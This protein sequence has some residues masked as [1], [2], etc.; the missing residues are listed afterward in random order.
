[1]KQTSVSERGA[2]LETAITL[3][4]RTGYTLNMTLVYHDEKTLAWAREIHT[5]V[6]KLVGK[7]SIRATWWK[8]N[9][10][11]QPGVLAGAVSTAMRADM[12]VTAIDASQELPLPFNVWVNTWLPNRMHS[13][14]CF[15]ALVSKPEKSHPAAKKAS[16]Y[17]RI[18]A[19]HGGFEFISEERVQPSVPI[20]FP[21]EQIFKRN[22]NGHGAHLR[23]GH[24]RIKSGRETPARTNTFAPAVLTF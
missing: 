8:I 5:K 7:D 1:M 16:E 21:R 9:E 6:G 11:G 14:G 15:V 2:K 22:G 19:E 10:L 23:N 13:A 17:L 12:I 18:V 24:A 20:T 4:P 3:T